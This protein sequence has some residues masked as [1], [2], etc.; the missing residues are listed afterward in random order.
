[1]DFIINTRYYLQDSIVSDDITLFFILLAMR[2][3]RVF[4]LDG[5]LF[6]SLSLLLPPPTHLFLDG[7]FELILEGAASQ[8]S[9]GPTPHHG[10][11][12]V[13]NGSAETFSKRQV[14]QGFCHDNLVQVRIPRLISLQFVP[15]ITA[16]VEHE[17]FFPLLGVVSVVIHAHLHRHARSSLH[18]GETVVFKIG[19]GVD[20]LGVSDDEPIPS[21][22]VSHEGILCG[23]TFQS[24]AGNVHAGH[25]TVQN[26]AGDG[27]VS[28]G[29]FVMVGARHSF[30]P[31]PHSL[32]SCWVRLSVPMAPP[33]QMVN[34]APSG[35]SVATAAA[36]SSRFCQ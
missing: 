6:L 27:R 19:V 16:L 12:R 4:L 24:S 26:L 2:L 5:H 17:Q 30:T 23:M 15:S 13:K 3:V 33:V 20:D 10:T 31:I 7:T 9:E 11:Q 35:E 34:C 28:L 8:F 21:Q 36:I 25:D 1:M 32:A 29:D 14:T 22:Q 18:G